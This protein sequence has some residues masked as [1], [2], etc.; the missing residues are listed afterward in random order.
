MTRLSSTNMKSISHF[1]EFVKDGIHEITGLST[2]VC[3]I[4]GKPMKSHGRCRRYLRISGEKRITLSL[5]V[6]FC[7]ECKRYHRELPDYI[8][9]YKHLSTEMISE[10][11]DD[12]ESYDIDDSTILRIR[13]WVSMFMLLGAATAKRLKI[14]HPALTIHDHFDSTVTA[15]TY[16]VKVVVN[17]NEWKFISLPVTSG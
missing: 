3:P 16:F 6:F 9:P 13:H 14:E 12:K 8:T 11:Y 2:P 10:I 7:P 1:H 4:C 17:S 15:L 5:R